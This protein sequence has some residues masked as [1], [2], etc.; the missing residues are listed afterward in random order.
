MLTR[1]RLASTMENFK[2]SFLAALED[3]EIVERYKLIF[4]PMFKTLML[5]VTSKLTDTVAML[6]QSITSLKK[7]VEEKDSIIRDLQSSVSRLQVTVDDLEQH[8]RRESMRVFG[9]PETTPGSTDDKVLE[10]VNNRMKLQPPLSL[11]EIAVSHRVGQVKPMGEDGAPPPPRPLLVKFVNRRSK[12]RVME[13][14]KRLRVR[15]GRRR[16]DGGGD[17]DNEGVADEED[18]NEEREDHPE[19]QPIIYISDDLTKTRA[20]LAFRARE[21]KRQHLIADTWIIDSKVMIKDN[22]SRIYHVK[23]ED[24]LKKHQSRM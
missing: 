13:V 1:G 14:R 10:L 22:R 16:H 8:G 3:E 23:S 2:P 11:D 24:E 7:E 4:E 15:R 20:T 18:S 17:A 21:S 5:P 12:A 6:S 19:P 9:L